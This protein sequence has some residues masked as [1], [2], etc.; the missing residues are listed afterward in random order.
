MLVC[1]FVCVCVPHSSP[2]G[3]YTVP[4]GVVH[5]NVCTYVFELAC[6]TYICHDGN[7]YFHMVTTLYVNYHAIDQCK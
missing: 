2:A 5:A 4:L 7:T 3:T 6:H 1:M